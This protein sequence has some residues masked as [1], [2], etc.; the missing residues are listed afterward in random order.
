MMSE[1][2]LGEAIY[3]FEPQEMLKEKKDKKVVFILDRPMD[4][5][6]DAYTSI[7]VK[8]MNENFKY[9]VVCRHKTFFTNSKA[10]WKKHYRAAS[11]RKLP[12][13]WFEK[14]KSYGQY[15]GYFVWKK[16]RLSSHAL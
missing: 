7:P 3:P 5:E 16:M 1:E 12:G 14:E 13:T 10:R 6:G 15:T 9:A 2:Y 4:P 11:K 8:P